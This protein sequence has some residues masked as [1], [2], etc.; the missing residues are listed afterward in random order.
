MTLPDDTGSTGGGNRGEGRIPRLAAAVIGVVAWIV[1]ASRRGAWRDEWMAEM[2][3]FRIRSVGRREVPARSRRRM[4]LRAFG[5]LSDALW[6]RMRAW[7]TNGGLPAASDAVRSLRRRPGF[8]LAVIGTLA[9]GIGSTTAIFTIVDGLMLRPLPFRDADRLVSLLG[10]GAAQSIDMD[11]VRFWKTEERIFADVRSYQPQSVIVTGAGEATSRLAWRVEPGLLEMLGVVPV[12]GRTLTSDDAVPGNDRA[13][14]LSHDVWRTAFGRDPR[15]LGRT[16]EL[17]GEPHEIVGVLP[18]TMRRLPFGAVQLVLPLADPPSIEPVLALA[19]LAP[20]ITL[21]MAQARADAIAEA[22]GRDRPRERGW[23]VVLR[24]VER[25]L[26]ESV[27]NGLWM[28]AAAVL[29]LLL[30]A[31][32]NAAGLLFL[33]GVQRRPEFALRAAL[34]GSRASLVRHVL[35]ESMILALAAGAAGTLLAWGAVHGMLRLVPSNLI[36]FSYTPVGLDVR[37]LIFASGLTAVVAL[38]F[39]ALPAWRTAMSLDARSA[40]RNY[41]GSKREVRLRGAVQVGQTALAML[42]LTGAGLFGRSFVE[43][44][45]VPLG[46]EPDRILELRLVDL[47]RLRGYPS[48]AAEFAR[49]LDERLRALPGV[50]GVAW[51]SGTTLRVGYR[52]ELDDGSV[53][54]SE[55]GL[56]PSISTGLDY[57]DVMGIRI[58]EGRAFRPG[59]DSGTGGAIIVDRDLAALLWPGQSPIGRT[60]RFRTQPPVTVVGVTDDVKLEG[61]DDPF[62]PLMMF[63]PTEPEA[64][65]SGVVVI[66]T[67]GDPARLAPAVRALIRE[68]DPE[69]PIASLQTGR[70]AL[71]EATADPRFLLVMVTAFATVAVVLAA[72]GVYGL[73]SF[74]VARRT[75]E[76]GVRM[77]LGA[78]SA[79]VVTD[80]VQSGLALAL[81]GLSLGLGAA[82]LLARLVSSLLFGVSPLDPAALGLA[83]AVLL[84]ACGVALVL[85][86]RRAA[87]VDPSE[88]IRAD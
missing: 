18:P 60:V 65:R 25:R 9:L 47:E 16:I 68:M 31:C 44:M 10:P 63:H 14:L 3:H 21:D 48:G 27:E 6:L 56:V 86:A 13:V 57:F 72:I 66:R 38:A 36:R 19:S 1:P 41:T 79:R 15:A 69:Q 49:S 12:L 78:R 32:S 74:D 75:R 81:L 45:S 42:L 64:L 71:G 73:V 88:A 84:G 8:A 46:Y 62:G 29:C 4:M 58:V 53:L 51:H 37:V 40:G 24:T 35:A 52:F 61:P 34:G 7:K 26:A 50:S 67:E 22:L 17:D 5:S 77:A 59:D 82:T 33:R 43:L 83:A 55:E 70:E 85:P 80:V 11:A 39:G 30:V 23:D 2:E 28:L 87:R 54:E 20:A 76:I